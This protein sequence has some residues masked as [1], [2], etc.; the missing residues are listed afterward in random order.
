MQANSYP[1]LANGPGDVAA[2]TSGRAK[3]L[4]NERVFQEFVGLERRSLPSGKESVDHAPRSRDDVSNAVAGVL[5]F[6]ET[7]P[8][9]GPIAAAVRVEALLLSSVELIR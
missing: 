7:K 6:L 9:R 2:I 1:D 3:L 8:N 4:E 5:R